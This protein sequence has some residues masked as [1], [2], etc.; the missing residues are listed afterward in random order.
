[1]RRHW[2]QGKSLNE[3]SCHPWYSQCKRLKDSK[4]AHICDRKTGARGN[5]AVYNTEHMCF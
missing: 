1:M 5:S 2:L 4:N 3:E